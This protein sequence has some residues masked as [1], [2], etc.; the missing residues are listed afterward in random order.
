MRMV[1]VL[2]TRALNRTLLERQMLLG[3]V[4]LPVPEAIE[5]L[6]GMQ[7]QEPRDPYVGLWSRLEGFRPEELADL[8]RSR[9]AVRGSMM[10]ATI[11]L[12][13]A[14]DYLALRPVMRPVLERTFRSTQF[15]RAVEGVDMDELLGA[16]QALLTEQPLI[17]AELRRL[18]AERWPDHDAESLANAV[19]FLLPL[20]QVTPRGL[21]T[22]SARAALTTPEVWLGRGVGEG[23]T[24]DD[25]VLRYLAAFGPASVADASNWSRLTR[26]REVFE[27]LRPRLRTFHNDE[28]RELFDVPEALVSDP[29]TP[30]PP[31]FLPVYDNVFLGHADRRRITQRLDPPTDAWWSAALLIDG[32]VAGTWKLERNKRSATLVIAPFVRLSKRNKA[33]LVE[34]AQSFLELIAWDAE[35]TDLRF[36][37]TP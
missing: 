2:S 35:A 26:L 12:V 15:A 6:V 20:V 31:R 36:Q 28:G 13:T 5:R 18:L 27:R 10:R 37:T 21:W 33:E 17:R 29:D 7:A 11:H 4:K 1:E 9:R 14:E 25:V 32:F 34:E 22:E 19:A 23:S 30:A 24:V 3:R 8:L 16:G